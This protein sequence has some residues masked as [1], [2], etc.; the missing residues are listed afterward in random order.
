MF[1]YFQRLHELKMLPLSWLGWETM[2]EG[3]ISWDLEKNKL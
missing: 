2:E 3:Y 1:E